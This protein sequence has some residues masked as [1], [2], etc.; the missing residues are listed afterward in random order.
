MQIG[1]IGLG[2][3]EANMVQHLMKGGHECVVFDINKSAVDK[4]AGQGA[5][6]SNSLKD[7]VSRLTNP[8]SV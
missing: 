6:G 1:M 2:R 4:L 7:F 8:R 5:I 3:I